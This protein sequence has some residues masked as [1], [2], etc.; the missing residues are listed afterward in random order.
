MIKVDILKELI[1]IKVSGPSQM[2]LT[3]NAGNDGPIHLFQILVSGNNT[4]RWA[5]DAQERI[6]GGSFCSH[7][8]TNCREGLGDDNPSD[9][10]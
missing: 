2:G 4:N 7:Y 3:I 6:K 8:S 1:N 5:D 9:V 10:I